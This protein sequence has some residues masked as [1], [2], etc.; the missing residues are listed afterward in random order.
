MLLC[1][2]SP[3]FMVIILFPVLCVVLA[4]F[5]L[6]SVLLNKPIEWYI[7]VVYIIA[8]LIIFGLILAIVSYYTKYYENKNKNI[9]PI[10]EEK[11]QEEKMSVKIVGNS[12]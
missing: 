4:V 2:A 12:T 10:V 8:G 9:W 7:W 11:K 5:M 3:M 1:L 6:A